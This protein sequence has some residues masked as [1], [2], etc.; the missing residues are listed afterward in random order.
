MENQILA[1][2]TLTD[3]HP[4]S[5]GNNWKQHQKKPNDQG[6]FHAAKECS[7]Q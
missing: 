6:G 3:I 1:G 7:P 2:F 4:V 5:Q